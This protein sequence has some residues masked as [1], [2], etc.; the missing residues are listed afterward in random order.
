[1]KHFNFLLKITLTQFHPRQLLT[2]IPV[3]YTLQLFLMNKPR[4][5][6]LSYKFIFLSSQ[7]HL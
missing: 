5:R 6:I 4:K 2:T 7:A 3:Y 1:M